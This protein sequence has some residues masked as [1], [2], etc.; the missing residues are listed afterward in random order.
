MEPLNLES[1]TLLSGGHSSRDEGVCLME[2]V[3]WVAGE[4]H[5]D[6]P[7]CTDPVLGAYGRAVNDF[8]TDEERRLLVPLVPRLVGTAGNA[9]LSLRRAMLIVDGTVRQVVPLVLEAAGLS[10]DADKLRKL[11]PIVDKESAEAAA[12]AAEAA[13]AAADAAYAADADADAA[14]DADADADAALDTSLATFAEDV[15]QILIDMKAP[16]CQWLELTEAA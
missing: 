1:L 4:P 15:V 6:R 8:M 13:E 2:A 3:A 9:A 7:E 11:S 14:Y 12:E 5:S 16:G 10:G